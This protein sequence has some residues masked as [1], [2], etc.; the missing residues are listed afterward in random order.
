MLC[1]LRMVMD[2]LLL[3]LL[4][5]C[6]YNK[7]YCD[8]TVVATRVTKKKQSGHLTPKCAYVTMM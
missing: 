3:I 2:M 4:S 8:I 7:P 6:L 5:V 1:F